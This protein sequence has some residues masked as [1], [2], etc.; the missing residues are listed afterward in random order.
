VPCVR[1]VSSR[2]ILS[3][4]PSVRP[5]VRPVRQDP[6]PGAKR[7]SGRGLRS[8]TDERTDSSKSFPLFSFSRSLSSVARRF[9]LFF[10]LVSF[11]F[12]RVLS[13]FD[14]SFCCRPDRSRAKRGKPRRSRAKYS[15]AQY[16]ASSAQLLVIVV[17]ATVPSGLL[18]F[19]PLPSLLSVL[20]LGCV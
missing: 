11:P 20:Q 5:S 16:S 15:T 10:S 8:R 9:F 18:C 3:A 4:R 7:A 1:P 17:A 14:P 13:P 2:S 19:A 12:G 6:C